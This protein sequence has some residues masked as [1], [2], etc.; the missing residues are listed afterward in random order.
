MANAVTKE[1]VKLYLKAV[2]K[3]WDAR[4]ASKFAPIPAVNTVKTDLD[5]LEDKVDDINTDNFVVQENGKGLSTNDFTDE[6]KTLLENLAR[7][8]D[9]AFD[10]Q[11]VLDIF[12]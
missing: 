9:S 1:A 11:D 6:H 12:N 4:N 3:E 2:V 10:Y 5:I 8:T 7:Q